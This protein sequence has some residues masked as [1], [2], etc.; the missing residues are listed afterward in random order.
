[1]H[2][3]IWVARCELTATRSD[4]SKDSLNVFSQK[5]FPEAVDV[6]CTGV[7]AFFPDGKRV[8]SQKTRIPTGARKNLKKQSRHATDVHSRVVDDPHQKVPA[9]FYASSLGKHWLARTSGIN[10]VYGFVRIHK[11][12]F[13]IW[14][15][16]LDAQRS[17]LSLSV[18][19]PSPS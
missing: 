4:R 9:R 15:D 12:S 16:S 17:G 6:V 3:A 13:R 14:L 8:V 1:M 7:F 18:V 10:Q 5:Q 2:L 19:V 11:A